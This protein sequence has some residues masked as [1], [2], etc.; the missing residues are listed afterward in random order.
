MAVARSRVL[1]LMKVNSILNRCTDA[2]LMRLQLQCSIFN[3]TFNPERQRLGNKVLRQ[4]LKGN[5]LASYYPPKFD[6]MQTLRRDYPDH[7]VED[8]KE[9]MRLEAVEAKKARGKGAPKKRTKEGASS[10]TTQACLMNT[11][12]SAK[13]QRSSRSG[14]DKTTDIHTSPRLIPRLYIIHIMDGITKSNKSC[15]RHSH[16]FCVGHCALKAPPEFSMPWAEVVHRAF[17]SSSSAECDVPCPEVSPLRQQR[18]ETGT[19]YRRD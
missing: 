15:T 6:V 5:I 16:Q 4:R 18:I 2:R 3:T 10:H 1:E 8:E 12:T 14:N 11:D 19:E 9:E 13:N 7:Q 17:A